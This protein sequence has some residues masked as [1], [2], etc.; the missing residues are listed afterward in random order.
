[1]PLARLG[2][3]ATLF[4]AFAEDYHEHALEEVHIF[5]IVR[6]LKT[7]AAQLPDILLAQHRRGREITDY[8]LRMAARPTLGA[9]DA[10]HLAAA[11]EG[12]VR[13]YEP[14]AAREDT[15]LFPAW[16][17]ALGKHGYD[18]MGERFEEIEH[19]TFGGDG[20]EDA[21]GKIRAI[22]AEFGQADLATMTAAKP[23]VD[24]GH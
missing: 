20:F 22:E 19:R 6:K 14:H 5:P 1:V 8:I 13:M 18:E 16:K 15:E 7:P 4:R 2:D 9:V 3:T 11:L 10:G 12:L 17:E 23:P 24:A 21:L